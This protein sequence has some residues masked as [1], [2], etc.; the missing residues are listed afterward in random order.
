LDTDH[1]RIPPAERGIANMMISLY[2]EFA[3]P[4]TDQTLFT[5]HHMILNGRQDIRA[6]GRY[7]D[8]DGHR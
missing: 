4:L 3:E 7:R 1:R 5:W 6:I 2:R 8:H